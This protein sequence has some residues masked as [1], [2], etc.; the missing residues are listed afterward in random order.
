MFEDAEFAEQR[1]ARVLA[2]LLAR[3][4]AWHDAVKSLTLQAPMNPANARVMIA[5]HCPSLSE[6]LERT[7]WSSVPQTDALTSSPSPEV[8]GGFALVTAVRLLESNECGEV[9]VCGASR[10]QSYFIHL[11]A[12]RSHPPER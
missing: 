8:A 5:A 6:L 7:G 12:A 3:H 9:L 2:T 10:A 11:G 4:C 1:G